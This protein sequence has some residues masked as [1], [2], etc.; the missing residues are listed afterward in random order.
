MRLWTFQTPDVYENLLKNGVYTCDKDNIQFLE[1][2]DFV[3]SYDWMSKQ[4][5]KKVGFSKSKYPL[6]A[7][8]TFDGKHKKP[9]LRLSGYAKRGKELVC[10]EIEIPDEKVL[11]SDFDLWHFV[12]NHFY[13]VKDD[14]YDEDDDDKYDN[15][16]EEQIQESWE[17]V[18]VD[19]DSTSPY[20]QA[21]FFELRK[22]NVK[23]VQFFKAK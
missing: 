22:E 19:K 12:L 10:L 18:F 16:S 1:D 8:Y 15:M 4:M 5:E 9:D 3:K 13:L 11:L 23:K 14:E 6:W 20:I 7:W 17:K 2:D 21:T